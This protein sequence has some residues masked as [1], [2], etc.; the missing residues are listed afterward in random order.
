M[1]VNIAQYFAADVLF[2]S[3]GI[4]HNTFRSRK[5]GDSQT[6]HHTGHLLHGSVLA[7]TGAAHAVQIL[8]GV[9]FGRRI[10]LERDLDGRVALFVGVELVSQDVTLLVENFSDSCLIFE[11][12]ASTTLWLAFTA[13]LIRV[14]KS[15]IGSVIMN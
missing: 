8:D 3:L 12:G 15:A 14:R 7:Q 9:G 6:V 10:P 11:P 4:G 2:T 1:L 13:F 5:D